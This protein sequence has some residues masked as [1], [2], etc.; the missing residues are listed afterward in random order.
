[1]SPRITFFRNFIPYLVRW[2]VNNDYYVVTRDYEYMGLDCKSPPFGFE[3]VGQ[4]YLFNDSTKPW[5]S[6]INFLKL[7]DKFMAITGT[8]SRCL[9]P[10]PIMDEFLRMGSCKCTDIELYN[11]FMNWSRWVG[12]QFVYLT[13]YQVLW[14]ASGS[15]T[16]HTLDAFPVNKITK[17]LKTLLRCML[18][19]NESWF[20][21]QRCPIRSSDPLPLFSIE[22]HLSSRIKF[23][24]SEKSFC[25][26][27]KIH[28]KSENLIDLPDFSRDYGILES[29][30]FFVGVDNEVYMFGDMYSD[31]RCDQGFINF[32]HDVN[33]YQHTSFYEW[34]DP[35]ANPCIHGTLLNFHR[36]NV[37]VTRLPRPFPLLVAYL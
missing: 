3:Q 23:F 31:P 33:L 2:D 36:P 32:L 16:W 34:R 13:N 8:L 17:T 14:L 26:R 30:W 22:D 5:N 1:M 37:W 12:I 20:T 15:I 29:M 28:L 19:P 24:I 11:L 4:C 9:N 10:N 21:A 6:T 25:S 35:R 18:P 27:L 7:R